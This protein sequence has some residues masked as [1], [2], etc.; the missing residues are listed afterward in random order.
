ME[1]LLARVST[2]ASVPLMLTF[3]LL[4][5]GIPALVGLPTSL[6][7]CHDVGV[8]AVDGI[9]AVVNVANVA[10]SSLLLP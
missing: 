3:F 1:S 10:R 9:S 8:P 7:P 2:V 4:V 5:A 6:A